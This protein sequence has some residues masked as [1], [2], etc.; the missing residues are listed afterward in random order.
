LPQTALHAN[1]S[2]KDFYGMNIDPQL[3][4]FGGSLIAIIAVSGLVWILR[5]GGKPSFRDEAAVKMAAGEVEDGF[6]A[7]RISISREGAAALALDNA[8]RI[9][10]IKRHGN[11]FA[12]R[13][14]TES[15]SV[16]EEVDAL[17]VHSGETRFG[18]VRL[19]IGDAASWA[20]AINR[21]GR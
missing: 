5:L 7:R 3:L 21:L 9:M 11:R 12:G 10:V 20:D 14:L 6:D 8:G 19:S 18:P 15:A 4:Q 16:R 17:I 13:V 2:H 1:P